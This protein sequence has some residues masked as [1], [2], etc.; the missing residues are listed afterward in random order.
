MATL[1][2][3][4]FWLDKAERAHQEKDTLEFLRRAQDILGHISNS[5]HLSINEEIIHK[6]M[7]EAKKELEQG[8]SIE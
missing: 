2:D 4:R 6:A 5:V 3:V 1:D 8:T 7:E